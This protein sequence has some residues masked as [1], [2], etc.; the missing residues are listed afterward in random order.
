MADDLV[1]AL[2]A[3]GV[4]PALAREWADPLAAAAALFGIRDR[5][6]PRRL[7]AFVAQCVHESARFTRLDEDLRYRNPARLDEL[8][9][10]VR[11]AADAAALIQLG[12]EAIANRVYSHRNGNGPESSGDGWRFRGRALLQITGRG[13]YAAAAAACRRPYVEHPEL[14]LQPSD[15]A[16]ASAW[17]WTAHGCNAP[18]DR[19]DV[20]GVTAVINPAMAGAEQRAALY[21][22]AL[23]ALGA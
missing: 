2:V 4:A 21:R 11:G 5:D 3:T 20:A 17:W 13:N 16:L 14:L 8:F 15:A 1:A 19:G 22:R 9:T 23:Q 10:A 12:P 7:A 6:R 18:A